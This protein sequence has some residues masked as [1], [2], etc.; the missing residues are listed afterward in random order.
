MTCVTGMSGVSIS[1]IRCA[2][3]GAKASV[4]DMRKSVTVSEFYRTR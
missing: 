2:D 3:V 1:C 4:V